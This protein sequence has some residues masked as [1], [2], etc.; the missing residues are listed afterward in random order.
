[1]AE[2]AG[3]N[4]ISQ[5]RITS[6]EDQRDGIAW[7]PPFAVWCAEK[8][9]ADPNAITNEHT[10]HL[11]DIQARLLK[12]LNETIDKKSLYSHIFLAEG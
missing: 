10:R 11:I 4:I 7:D 2:A 8:Y 3:W 5:D 6:G 1:M 12:Q 9:L